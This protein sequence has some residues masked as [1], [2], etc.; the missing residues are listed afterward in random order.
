M[1]H[2]PY[3]MAA[4]FLTR[5]NPV[6]AMLLPE[7][8]SACYLMEKKRTKLADLR[9]IRDRFLHI[10]LSFLTSGKAYTCMG[11]GVLLEESLRFLGALLPHMGAGQSCA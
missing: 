2:P 10:S 8:G 3:L 5:R 9:D 7:S 11:G 1:S 4:P 6:L